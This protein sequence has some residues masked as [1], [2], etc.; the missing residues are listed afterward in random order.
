MKRKGIII[1]LIDVV[2][3]ILLG[4]LAI[5]DFQAKTP[6]DLPDLTPD[7][8][9]VKEPELEEIPIAEV[10]IDNENK[11]IFSINQ[12]DTIILDNK[13]DLE[14]TIY[15]FYSRDTSMVVLILPR[16]SSEVQATVDVIDICEKYE[17]PR[18]L[19]F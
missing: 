1:R 14:Y 19:T 3:I 16:D 7:E 4:F 15:D 9:I 17:I 13:E 6:I 10:V 5:S 8:E 2:L 11:F 18:N 12:A